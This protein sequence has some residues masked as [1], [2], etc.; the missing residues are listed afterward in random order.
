[1]PLISASDGPIYP[2]AT[3]IR[4]AVRL[5]PKARTER[6]DGIAPDADG[7]MVLRISVTVPPSE[8]RANDALL[9]FLAR[10]WRLRRRDFS[11]ISGSKSRNKLVE[12]AGDPAILRERIEATLPQR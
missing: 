12:I 5:T 7:K 3:G 1:M 4:I 8:G 6:I 10:E 2:S 11:L 9:H